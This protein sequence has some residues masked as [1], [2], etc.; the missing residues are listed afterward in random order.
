VYCWVH[1]VNRR[2]LPEHGEDQWNFVFNLCWAKSDANFFGVF[3][4]PAHCPN[5]FSFFSI[6]G[7]IDTNSINPEVAGRDN[8]AK[9]PQRHVDIPCDLDIL[10][11]AL[12]PLYVTPW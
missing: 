1:V 10:V 4:Y 7:L 3:V 9:E 11:V 12:H 2:P 8:L 6:V 5:L